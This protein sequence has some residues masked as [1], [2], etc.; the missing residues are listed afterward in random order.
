MCASTSS[1]AAVSKGPRCRWCYNISL[2]RSILAHKMKKMRERLGRIQADAGLARSHGGTS[3]DLH[4]QDDD[5]SRRETW[6]DFREYIVGREEDR[7]A[8]V[9]ALLRHTEKELSV[10]SI[11]G[12]GG[13]GKTTLARLAFNAEPVIR[14]FDCRVWIHVSMK[15]DLIKIGKSILSKLEANCSGDLDH[16]KTQLKGLLKDK[17]FL[18]VLDDIWE[19]DPHE[20]LKLMDF[21]N[22]GAKGSMV[23]VTTRYEKIAINMDPVLCHRLE[24]LSDGECWDLFKE[25]AFV[26]QAKEARLQHIGRDIVKKCKGVPLAVRSLAFVLKWKEGVDEWEDIRDSHLWELE[27]KQD[28]SFESVLPSLK[29]SFQH[30]SATLKLC[31]VYCSVFPKGSYIDKDLLIQQWIALGFIRLNEAFHPERRGEEYVKQLLGMSFLQIST[32]QTPISR[33][34]IEAPHVFRLHDLVYDLA[35]S[36]AMV[37]LLFLDTESNLKV[38]STHSDCRYAVLTNC[39][40]TTLR[41]NMMRKLRALHVNEWKQEKIPNKIFSTKFLRVLNLSGCSLLVLPSCIKQLKLLRYL[42]A[43]G[44]QDQTLNHLGSLQNLQAL[45]LSGSLI[46]ALPHDTGSLEKLRY[47]NLSGCSNL[48][49]LPES[50]CSLGKLQYLDMSNC[51][52][53]KELPPHFGNLFSLSTLD[54]SSCC[55]LTKLPE[56]LGSLQKLRVLDLSNCW[57]LD[58]L[59]DSFAKLDHLK[60]LNLSCCYQ[61]KEL[62]ELF[63]NLETL[64]LSD[65]HKLQKLPES[66]S[67]LKNL[68]VLILS[69]CWELTVLPESFGNLKQLQYLDLS[70]SQISALPESVSELVNLEHMNISWCTDLHNLPGNYGNLVK[71][72]ELNMSYIGN[73]N[74][75][76]PKGI[77]EMSNLKILLADGL[78]NWSWENEEDIVFFNA[79]SSSRSSFFF[80]GENKPSDLSIK[81]N[82]LQVGDL[83]RVQNLAEVEELQL[84]KRRQ[85]RSLIVSGHGYGTGTE[86]AQELVPQE[87]VLE[88]LQPPRTLE[89]F[90]L[91]GCTISTFPSWMTDIASFLPNLAHLE[92]RHLETCGCLP[93]LGQLPKLHMLVISDMPHIK[94]VNQEFSGGAR[95]FQKLRNIV[96]ENMPNL[97]KWH[98][99]ATSLTS[100]KFLGVRHCKGLDNWRGSIAMLTSLKSLDIAMSSV[101]ECLGGVTSLECLK[102]H[103]CLVNYNTLEQVLHLTALVDLSL[104][105]SHPTKLVND[106]EVNWLMNMAS[107]LENLV[108]LELDNFIGCDRLPPLGCLEKLRSLTLRQMPDLKTVHQDISGGS[109]CLPM[110]QTLKIGSMPNLERWTTAHAP[111]AHAAHVRILPDLQLLK[112][113]DCPKLKFVPFLPVCSKC[114]ISVTSDVIVPEHHD[115]PA[116]WDMPTSELFCFYLHG[117][118]TGLQYFKV[119]RL[120]SVYGCTNMSSWQES[121]LLLTSLQKLELHGSDMPGWLCKLSSLRE[122]HIIKSKPPLNL[123]QFVYD[124]HQIALRIEDCQGTLKQVPSVVILDM[125]R[126]ITFVEIIGCEPIM[127][128]EWRNGE[129]FKCKL[130]KSSEWYMP[131]ADAGSLPTILGTWQEEPTEF[132]SGDAANPDQPGPSGTK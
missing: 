32:T 7:E 18:I 4:D 58:A 124:R 35:R 99:D 90:E 48:L 59:S 89:R 66:I 122:L 132:L 14:A 30:M 109:N 53:I 10:I 96:I 93:P 29:L 5:I 98:T 68:K 81:D 110:L 56:S 131:D 36:L 71:L 64:D 1:E 108:N 47:L 123:S 63:G 128:A 22:V 69:D 57:K 67:G 127:H 95:P 129:L 101:P 43:S 2:S 102:I 117:R 25:T 87:A 86:L 83:G 121:I 113:F 23:L 100:L 16:L 80:T 19:E 8:V 111:A 120:L 84:S 26:S 75:N 15:Y 72:E 37:D 50:L 104:C 130:R 46:G 82:T 85:L 11:H 42:D 78:I 65:C 77:A 62:P 54:L 125:I 52:A 106:Q 70:S 33:K 27:E 12:F 112:V 103:N 97:E 76:I 9:S 94:E 45:K 40:P 13:L 34:C 105:C 60:G 74:V 31:F 51:S 118:C 116:P 21:L 61:L 6:S 73:G 88:K 107:C 24:S 79:L 20:L 92:L 91:L 39:N 3:S 28:I 44:M 17:T 41:N 114:I 38:S 55:D 115:D 126:H 119:L 49:V